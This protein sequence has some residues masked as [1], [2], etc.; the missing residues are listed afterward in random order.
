MGTFIKALKTSEIASGAM[1]ELRVKDKTVTIANVDGEFLT[2]DA[3][4]THQQCALAGGYL[5]GYT[6]TCYCHG[7]MF[8]VSTG[9]VLGPP[10][11]KSITVYKT[12]VVGVDILVEI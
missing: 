5:D 4:C 10:A 1:K 3:S 2:F 12:K 9:N 7:A 11:T 8:D 6:L